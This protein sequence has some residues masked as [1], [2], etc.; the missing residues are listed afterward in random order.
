MIKLQTAD[1]KPLPTLVVPAGEGSSVEQLVA[2]VEENREQILSELRQHG[3]LLFRGFGFADLDGFESFSRALCPALQSSYAGGNSPRHR[4]AGSVFTSTEYPKGERISLHNEASYLKE[5]PRV[6]MFYCHL[7]ATSGGQTP[8]ADCRKILAGI[9]E[10]VRRRFIEK[11]VRYINNLHGGDGVGRSWQ[12]AFESEDRAA[13]EQRL[14]ADGYDYQWRPDGSLR[15]SMVCEAVA[16]HPVT[17]EESW[18]NQAEQ[19]HPSGLAPR[20]RRA[21]QSIMSEEDFPHN[22][23]FGDG[24]PMAETDLEH[25]R[26]V[27]RAE[28]RVFEWQ[29]GDVLVCDNLLVAHGRQPYEGERRVLVSLA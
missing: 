2:W 25:I 4:V 17:G 21:L 10:D 15:T 7:P 16:R 20:T 14:R 6:I 23:T 22:A 8:V 5:M 12:Q 13:V 28:E 3:A 19:W 9:R 24:S 1:E 26:E 18:I 11:K 27:M 29:A